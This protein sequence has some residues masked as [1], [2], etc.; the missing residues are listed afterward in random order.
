M[1]SAFSTVTCPRCGSVRNLGATRNLLRYRWRVG[2]LAL[3]GGGS[4]LSVMF[5]LR[6]LENG[7]GR[8]AGEITADRA[9]AVL[10]LIVALAGWL[11]VRR[12]TG[13]WRC[14]SCGSENGL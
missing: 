4:A 1:K 13:G 3:I 6:S 7:S 8:S 9:Q 12:K 11:L 14:H 5:F 10:A 2:G